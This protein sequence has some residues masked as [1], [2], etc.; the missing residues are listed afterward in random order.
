MF[1][2]EEPYRTEQGAPVGSP[3]ARRRIGSPRRIRVQKK[4]E[5]KRMSLTA[6]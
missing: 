2:G 4:T 1:S 6:E 5:D 3:S